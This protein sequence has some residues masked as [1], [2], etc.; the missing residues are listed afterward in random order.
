MKQILASLDQN[1]VIEGDLCKPDRMRHLLA[2][3]QKGGT[4]R[5]SGLSYVAAG[6][7]HSGQNISTEFFN[8]IIEFDEHKQYLKVETGCTLGQ[9]FE[10]LTPKN[11]QLP[12]QPGYPAI[13]I[14]GCV[15]G[16]VH[17][18]NHNKD[19]VFGR[20]ILELTLFHPSHGT[21]I[22][23]PSHHSDIF[24]LTIGGFGL[25]GLIID[26]TL[27]LKPLV[28][29]EMSVSNIT[30]HS[31][32]DG[33]EKIL[34][35]KQTADM[36]LGWFDLSNP[37]SK[38][39][40]QGFVMHGQYSFHHENKSDN[41]KILPSLNSSPSKRYKISL[42][43]SYTLPIINYLYRHKNIYWTKSQTLNLEKMLFPAYGKEA[44]FLG[45]G[46]SGF[47][48]QQNLI[49]FGQVKRYLKEFIV[50]LKKHN[51]PV[52]LTTMKLF[53][54]GKENFLSYDGS[55]LSFTIDIVNNLASQNFLSDLDE[56]N[57]RVG[58]KTSILKDS[59]LPT[60]IIQYQY[61]KYDAFK[62][63]LLAFDPKRLFQSELSLRIGL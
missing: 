18:K 19:G 8:R 30:A 13:T 21:I 7:N 20:H 60:K 38:N 29:R 53:D 35:I 24:D 27:K 48:E 33:Y 56:L 2:Y 37:Q 49:P 28:N 31:L 47:I 40:G 25:T 61:K 51:I 63:E 6:L 12:V 57:C 59:R 39:L 44:Y 4:I 62:R 9:I 41:E 16:N 46:K 15:A 11:L 42:F 22:C 32:Y 43:N 3:V 17:G 54:N 10:F 58:A 50:C 45:F 55:G 52:A 23:S 5:G 14:G 1:V 26:V 36:A 34:S